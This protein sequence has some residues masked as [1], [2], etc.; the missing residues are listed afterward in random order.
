MDAGLLVDGDP[1]G[2]SVNERRNVL[3]RVLD[4][5]VAV[6]R[7][8]N[9]FAQRF[10]HRRSNGDIGDK[11]AVHH[12]HVQDRPATSNCGVGVL[13]EPGEIGR[14]NGRR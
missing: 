8:V 10:N 4:H 1:V 6:E 7:H 9:R 12:V 13:G 5:Q 3:V 11:M 14:Q 2:P